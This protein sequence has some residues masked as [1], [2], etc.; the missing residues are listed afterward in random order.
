MNSRNTNKKKNE[1]KTGPPWLRT[2]HL[3]VKG[4]SDLLSL[5]LHLLLLLLLACNLFKRSSASGCLRRLNSL[6]MRLLDQTSIRPV[7]HFRRHSFG[8]DGVGGTG[9]H[10]N[11]FFT[12]SP[13]PSFTFTSSR[14]LR[15]LLDGSASF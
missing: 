13:P 14:H 7:F 15:R 5:L 4:A 1:I 9:T 3:V 2:C 12:S 8:I 10:L 6:S 11:P